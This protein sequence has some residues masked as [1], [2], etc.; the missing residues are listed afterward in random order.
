MP[1]TLEGPYSAFLDMS[2]MNEPKMV[3]NIAILL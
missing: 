1:L 3:F 2:P